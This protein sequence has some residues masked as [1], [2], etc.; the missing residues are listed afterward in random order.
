MSAQPRPLDEE[1]LRA[2]VCVEALSW[3]GTPYHS[4][5][6]IKGVGVDCASLIACV[7]E[8]VGI[9]PAYDPG[10]YPTSWH[11]HRSE[12]RFIR[13][14]I[15]AGA[16]EIVDRDPIP[17]DFGVWKFGRCYSHGGILVDE[18]GLVV[19]SY[20]HVGVMA[21]RRSEEPLASRPVRWFTFW[22]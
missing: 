21:S 17:G 19:H 7:A 22:S 8:R 15:E 5:G 14:A 2:A 1:A 16:R 4:H 12:E 11:L 9:I 20:I 10:F 6:R 18:T 3:R 13:Q